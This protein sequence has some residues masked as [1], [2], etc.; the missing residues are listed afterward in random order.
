MSLKA[1]TTKRRILD[2][3]ADLIGVQ[4]YKSTRLESILDR[5]GVSKGNFYHHFP[6]KEDLGLAVLGHF[7]SSVQ[8]YLDTSMRDHDDPLD[9]LDAMF[10]ALLRSQ[11]EKDCRGG[12]PL[13]N[14]AAEMSDV[15][16]GFRE[17][18]GEFFQDWQRMIASRLT[19][20]ARRHGREGLDVQGLARHIICCLEGAVLMA[21][22]SRELDGMEKSVAHLKSY[23]R[24]QFT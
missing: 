9:Q 15:H 10:D 6:S 18:L 1:E 11:S 24:Q 22:V 13:G 14:L 8:D 21:K 5:S 17:Q 16:E 4:G 19:A 20:A 7:G 12:C 2:A 23:V 3:A